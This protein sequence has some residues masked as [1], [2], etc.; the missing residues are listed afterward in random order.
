MTAPLTIYHQGKWWDNPWKFLDHE[1]IQQIMDAKPEESI[2][3]ARSLLFDHLRDALTSRTVE[4]DVFSKLFRRAIRNL[5]LSALHPTSMHRTTLQQYDLAVKLGKLP[6]RYIAEIEGISE[7]TARNRVRMMKSSVIYCRFDNKSLM[8]SDSTLPQFSPATAKKIAN[9]LRSLDVRCAGSGLKDCLGMAKGDK[10]VC[11]NCAPKLNKHH[12]YHQPW[13]LDM[14][15]VV[16]AEAIAEAKAVLLE[17]ESVGATL[18]YE[19]LTD[20]A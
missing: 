6:T 2:A 16:K 11:E 9:K 10:C 14:V 20:A 8:Y 19:R 3:K 7:R 18:A 12:P 13:L 4:L 5:E 1:E 15:E 17:T